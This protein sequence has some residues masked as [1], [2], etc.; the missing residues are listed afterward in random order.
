MSF[1]AKPC[2]NLCLRCNAKYS[3]S[4][5][6]SG[7]QFN[8]ATSQCE[9]IVSNFSSLA[10]IGIVGLGTILVIAMIYATWSYK[11]RLAQEAEKATIAK[12]RYVDVWASP[13]AIG[14]AA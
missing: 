13:D 3:C 7:Y 10:I 6:A 5:C 9:A 2:P 11:V 12:S 4:E 14:S 8:L 1:V